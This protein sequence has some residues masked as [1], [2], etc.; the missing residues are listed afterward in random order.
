MTTS[1]MKTGRTSR[2]AIIVFFA[3]F[4]VLCLIPFVAVLSISFSSERDIVFNG[5][6]L[7]PRE[8]DLSAY[9]H[10]FSSPETL[11]QSY[12]VTIFYSLAG[13]FASVFV[14]A[15][16][17]YPLSRENFVFKRVI[18]FYFFFT[19]LF[20]GGLTPGYILI[21]RY[22]KLNDTIWVFLI[23]GLV[24]VWH[25]I[26]LRTFFQKIPLSIIES[27]KI[28]GASESR[29]FFLLTIPLSKPVLATVAFFGIMGRWNDWYTAMLYISRRQD[30]IPLQYLLQRIMD[31]MKFLQ[32][33]NIP[34]SIRDSMTFPDESVRMAMCVLA[35]G[36][37][38]F[39]FP[40]FQ[41]HFV[42][43]MTVGSLKG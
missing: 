42:K 29:I 39:I 10:I 33:S 35:A 8:I 5:Y 20:S 40:F 32:M 41:K 21:T 28:D 27:A 43:G 12:K 37:V 2:F 3:L 16:A 11:V 4:S 7:F 6:S 26:L 17:A 34:Q 30:L 14:M 9:R 19:L 23:P 1:I 36:P 15:L 13:T 24:N 38:L 22:L 31:N 25:V 18:S